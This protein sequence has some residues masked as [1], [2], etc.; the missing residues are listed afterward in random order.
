MDPVAAL[1]LGDALDDHH[2]LGILVGTEDW[3]QVVGL[4]HEADP[5]AAQVAELLAGE[6]PEVCALE[7][8]SARRRRVQSADQVERGR[9]ARAGRAADRRE[10]PA[11]HRQRQAA[12][13]LDPLISLLVDL[14]N[15][16][17]LYD[18][19]LTVATVQTKG[20]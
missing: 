5:V 8:D 2:D 4:K 6:H 7:S 13:R 19:G 18:G 16:L 14:G 20:S 17:E 11:A 3:Q 12:Q 10:L 1:R 9:L 15:I